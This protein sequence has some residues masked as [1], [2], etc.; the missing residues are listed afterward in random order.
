MPVAALV[1]SG[2][3][4]VEEVPMRADSS[5]FLDRVLR[6]EDCCASLSS[7]SRGDGAVIET[8]CRSRKKT[9]EIVPKSVTRPSRAA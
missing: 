9:A 2:R 7:V 5:V 1:S 4:A 3:G 8:G 6:S